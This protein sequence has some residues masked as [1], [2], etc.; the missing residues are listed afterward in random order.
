M[1][2]ALRVLSTLFLML[3]V[4]QAAQA[5]TITFDDI[6]TTTKLLPNDYSYSGLLWDNFG[7]AYSAAYAS[8]LGYRTGVVSGQYAAYNGNGYTATLRSPTTFTLN[9]AYFTSAFLSSNTV[10]VKGYHGTDQLYQSAFTLVDPKYP[11]LHV[12]DFVNIDRVT[13]STGGLGS[14]FVMDNLTY[15]EPV[16]PTPI[17][18]AVWLLGSGIACLTG[19]RKRRAKV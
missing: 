12:F 13:F 2:A 18:A 17:P 6:T 19:F 10:T 14:Q 11:V 3:F 7:V 4:A 8:N 9:S 5:T 1:K 16:T 15:N